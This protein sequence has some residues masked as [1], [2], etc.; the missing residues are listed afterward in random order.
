MLVALNLTDS[1]VTGSR[2]IFA[3]NCNTEGGWLAVPGT[4]RDN[5]IAGPFVL[6]G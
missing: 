3:G 6:K 1:S 2:L 5:K 4:V